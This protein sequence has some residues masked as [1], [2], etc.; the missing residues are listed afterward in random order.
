VWDPRTGALQQE[1]SAHSGCVRW[2]GSYVNSGDESSTILVSAG[3][4]GFIRLMNPK[5]GDRLAKIRHPQQIHA[6][7]YADL[8]VQAEVVQVVY[9]TSKPA[10]RMLTLDASDR[11]FT[12]HFTDIPTPDHQK[13]HVMQVAFLELPRTGELGVAV[14]SGSVVRIHSLPGGE[15]VSS[16]AGPPGSSFE[17]LAVLNLEAGQWLAAGAADG[18]L[19]M[20]DVETGEVRHRLTSPGR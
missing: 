20:W 5:T 4:D 10:L 15:V 19:M 16:L 18:V 2:I 14:T 9:S 3:D 1:V 11:E 7:K 12:P 8:H 17:A 6:I 13:E